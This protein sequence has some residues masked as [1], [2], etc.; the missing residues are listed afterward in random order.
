MKLTVTHALAVLVATLAVACGAGSTADQP[1]SG[2]LNGT[3]AQLTTDKSSYAPAEMVRL[4]I[5]NGESARLAYN[6][7]TRELELRQGDDWVPGPAS[8][9]L[10]SR[11]VWYVEAGETRTATTDLDLGLSAGEYRMVLTLARDDAAEGD[12]IRAVSNTFTI[13]P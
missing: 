11:E 13:T 1:L 10:C 3:G 12:I 8:L 4:T 7:C 2:H 5:Q 6:A 9:R